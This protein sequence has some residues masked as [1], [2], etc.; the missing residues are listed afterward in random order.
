MYPD[1]HHLHHLLCIHL[2]F[3]WQHRPVSKVETA[4]ILAT[5]STLACQTSVKCVR[6]RMCLQ[7]DPEMYKRSNPLCSKVWQ[8]AQTRSV[9]V[10]QCWIFLLPGKCDTELKFFLISY[11]LLCLIY[12]LEK[13]KKK[14]RYVLIDT[15]SHRG[16][17]IQS[18]IMQARSFLEEDFL[19]RYGDHSVRNEGCVSA[20]VTVM[21][22]RTLKLTE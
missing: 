1:K 19:V 21:P 3:G 16:F 7:L 22:I 6:L 4:V 20:L 17:I 11:F 5:F 2:W 9:C 12:G 10:L 18:A 14:H 15:P 8:T 13:K